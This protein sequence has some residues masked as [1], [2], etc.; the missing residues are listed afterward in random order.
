MDEKENSIALTGS[1]KRESIVTFIM[2]YTN[3]KSQ[4][5]ILSSLLVDSVCY[6]EEWIEIS[7]EGIF[8]GFTNV[9]T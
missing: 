8:K 2:R 3:T 4:I 6:V 7:I 9:R 1:D 5:Q